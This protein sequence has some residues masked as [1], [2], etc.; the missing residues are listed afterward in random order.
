[1]IRYE[2]TAYV[3]ELS[4]LGGMWL[5]ERLPWHACE[6]PYSLQPLLLS[7]AEIDAGEHLIEQLAM[8]ALHL[9]MSRGSV[10]ERLRAASPAVAARQLI[11]VMTGCM[12]L[13]GP[14]RAFSPVRPNESIA[15]ALLRGLGLRDDEF[16]QQAMSAML[17][18]LADHE[19]TSST[20]AARLAA[21][22]G[23]LLH[24]CVAAALATNSGIEIGRLYNRVEAFVAPPSDAEKLLL[25][26]RQMQDQGETPPGFNHPIYPRGD[27]RADHLLALA[28]QRARKSSRLRALVDFATRAR[29][30]MHLHPRVE[31]GVVALAIAMQAPKGSTG[32]LFTVARTA[33]WIAHVLEQRTAGFL[34]RPRARYLPTSLPVPFEQV[35]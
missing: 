11:Q 5:E 35:E 17:V 29:T 18:L 23:V 33:G 1:L 15:E 24:G 3:A 10:V 19:L 30:T 21:S 26:A 8:V 2:S 6:T 4:N 31:L 16:N 9:G 22:A 34:L 12:G 7:V 25:R 20:F 27:P 28:A 14:G 13:I 32:A